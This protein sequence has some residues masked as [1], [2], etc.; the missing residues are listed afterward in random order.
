MIVVLSHLCVSCGAAAMVYSR[1]SVVMQI[2]DS[3]RRV[4]L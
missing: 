4:G 2:G 3:T 1:S